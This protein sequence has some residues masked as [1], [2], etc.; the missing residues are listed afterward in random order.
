MVTAVAARPRAVPAKK[1]VEVIAAPEPTRNDIVLPELLRIKG[2]YGNELRVQDVV[3]EAQDK[4]S[5]IHRYFNWDDTEAA[6]Q[7]RLWQARQLISV[8]VVM[9]EYDRRPITAFVHLRT[10]DVY[11]TTVEVMSDAGMR[12]RLLYEFLDLANT[13]MRKYNKLVELAPV[14][15]AIKAVNKKHKRK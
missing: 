14:F 11:R 1:N 10:E 9:T 15:E 5:P 4:K 12:E 13:F 8:V 3:T 6:H 7:Y 2:K